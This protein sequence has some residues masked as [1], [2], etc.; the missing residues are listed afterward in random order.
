MSWLVIPGIVAAAL[1]TLA[2]FV[3]ARPLLRGRML[4]PALTA[5]VLGASLTIGIGV[6]ADLDAPFFFVA[7]SAFAVPILVLM[8][9]AA[10]GSGASARGRWLLMLTWGAL[11][12]PLAALVPIWATLAC[13]GSDCE[14]QD[15]GGV[16]P[17]LVS[18]SAFV[19][20][21]WLPAGVAEAPLATA[22]SGRRAAGAILLLWLAV[23]GWIVPLEGAVDEFSLRILLA[24]VLGPQAG[25]VGWLIAD[26]ARAVPRT[27]PRS[28]LLGLIAGIAGMLPG[29]ATVAF[30]WLL[31]VG[32]L[33][34]ALGSLAH[35]SRAS[36]SAGLATRWGVVVLV[37]SAVGFLAPA[38]SGDSVGILF[39]AHLDV[40]AVPVL[41]FVGVTLFSVL[42]SAPAWVLLRR[43]ASRERV[44]LAIRSDGTLDVMPDHDE[45]P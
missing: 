6:A 23:V 44:P 41:S 20:L 21:A 4:W 26:R 39:T 36:A 15:F 19:L 32:A 35:S 25:A 18:S 31:G 42:L 24:A 16:L 30:P 1:A 10:I 37:A 29:A 8:E 34:G 17:L 3:L 28:L 12:F 45:R 7:I 5:A 9:A 11:I 2:V 43:S 27:V 14:L 38:V 13:A 22:V 40:L 33:A